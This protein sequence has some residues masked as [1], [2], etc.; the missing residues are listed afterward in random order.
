MFRNTLPC[1]EGA[2]VDSGDASGQVHNIGYGFLEEGR[3]GGGNRCFVV[4]DKRCSGLTANPGHPRM[5]RLMQNSL[6]CIVKTTSQTQLFFLF[7]VDLLL[8]RD[9]CPARIGLGG[10]E[11][12]HAFETVRGHQHI[13]ARFI[14]R[15]S[16]Y[17]RHACFLSRFPGSTG[18][19]P[20]FSLIF[21]VVQVE[22]MAL[23]ILVRHCVPFE[24]NLQ[25]QSQFHKTPTTCPPPLQ[26]QLFF[27]DRNYDEWYY[28]YYFF[29][30]LCAPPP[31]AIPAIEVLIKTIA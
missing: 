29:Q 8:V 23:Y 2:G 15:A 31:R 20:F 27:P 9:S 18:F 16:A 10:S 7:R 5:I 19:P 12:V 28:S 13:C 22:R 24:L 30:W 4:I 1:K 25:D 14:D 11:D 26:V 17:P 3:I 21:M 6:P